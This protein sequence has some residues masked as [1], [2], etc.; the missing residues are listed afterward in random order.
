MQ[1][2]EKSASKSPDDISIA[3][4]RTR[5]RRS[6]IS[7]AQTFADRQ[8]ELKTRVDLVEHQVGK[9]MFSHTGMSLNEAFAY[10]DKDQTAALEVGEIKHILNQS[11]SEYTEEE[12]LELMNRY[13]EDRSGGVTL[14]EFQ[15]RYRVERSLLLKFVKDKEESREGFAELPVIGLFFVA[16][17]LLLYGHDLTTTKYAASTGALTGILSPP[18]GMKLAAVTSTDKFWQWLDADLVDYA[19]VQEDASGNTLPSDEWGYISSFNKYVSPC[20]YLSQQR[21]EAEECILSQIGEAFGH[22][23]NPTNKLSSTQFGPGCGEGIPVENCTFHGFEA[24]PEDQHTFTAKLDYK[25]PKDTLR[26]TIADLKKNRWIDKR[27]AWVDIKYYL[28][29]LQLGTYTEVQLEFEFSRGG[30]VV[31]TYQVESIVV[32]PYAG[33]LIAWAVLDALWI[34]FQIY[35]AAIEGR[36][37]CQD[38]WKEY[39]KGISGAWNLLDWAQ[40]IIT[41]TVAGL[42]FTIVAYLADILSNS[43]AGPEQYVATIKLIAGYTVWYKV[44]SVANLFILVIRFFKGFSAQPR[45]RI[46]VD[47]IVGAAVDLAHWT[48]IFG[49]ILLTFSMIALFLFG[50]R[51]ETYS[52]SGS[53][54]FQLFRGWIVANSVPVN[55]FLEAEPS[56]TIVWYLLFTPLMLFVLQKMVLGIVLGAFVKT[57]AGNRDARTLWSQ[58]RDFCVDMNAQCKKL[59]KLS[60]VISVLEDPFYELSLKERVCLADILASY[61]KLT[62]L[63]EQQDEYAGEFCLS[64]MQEFFANYDKIRDPDIQVR[65]T[66]AYARTTQL[67][68]DFSDLN[69]RLEVL[70]SHADEVLENLR[71][72]FPRAKFS[73]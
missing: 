27:T 64:I 17:I 3:V 59:M 53:A 70:E 45:L 7:R 25:L 11:D 35:T 40:I 18:G 41:L 15:R 43:S 62:E 13:D 33:A 39:S 38:G 30:R 24:D 61:R 28:L 71:A 36:Q 73:T 46:V 48:V 8:Q 50:H 58:T 9:F 29:N 49:C 54:L 26:R 42:W 60:D 32:N 44:L 34:A 10:F 68:E 66:N 23:C 63:T 37:L 5:T 22:D 69:E 2:A 67:N 47:S 19:F 51:I 14:K 56:F 21:T 4:L 52:N 6:T 16:F 31:P 65:R 1:D 57:R 12:L 55:D 72:K 20:V